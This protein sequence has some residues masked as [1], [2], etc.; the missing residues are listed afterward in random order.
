MA[1]IPP[2]ETITVRAMLV[3]GPQKPLYH[4]VTRV[5]P[6]SSAELEEHRAF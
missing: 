5:A 4:G 3:A 6:G 2:G 1:P